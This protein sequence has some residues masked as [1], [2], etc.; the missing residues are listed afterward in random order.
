MVLESKEIRWKILCEGRVIG[1]EYDLVNLASQHGII[2]F[3]DSNHLIITVAI[4]KVLM[5]YLGY[6]VK[7][8][9]T[10]VSK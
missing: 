2:N 3:S 10:L 5:E 7:Y 6:D 1:K 9:V 4:V 8:N